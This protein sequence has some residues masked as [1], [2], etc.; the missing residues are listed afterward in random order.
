[1]VFES[2]F[3]RRLAIPASE[4]DLGHRPG[5]DDHGRVS[6]EPHCAERV[7]ELRKGLYRLYFASYAAARM[8]TWGSG[9]LK[10]LR[11]GR[12]NP[13]AA[14][15]RP[16]HMGI[17]ACYVLTPDF[18]RS[19][20]QLDSRIFMYGEE[21]LL[22]GQVSAAGGVTYYEPNLRVRHLESA[23]VTRLPSQRAYEYARASFPIY[24]STCRSD[25][26]EL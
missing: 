21:A 10:K 3:C 6:P 17:G 11:G 13:L 20:A 1:L 14:S 19:Y 24:R 25:G 7:G 18:F 26:S 5:R 15:A 4:A 22:A 8:L 9:M 16:I 12:V 2:D 23:T